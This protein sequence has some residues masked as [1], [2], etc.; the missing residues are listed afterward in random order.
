MK[1]SVPLSI[2]E[3]NDIVRKYG[4]IAV[5][6]R[7]GKYYLRKINGKCI[8]LKGNICIIQKDKPIA[9]RLWPFYIFRK[10]I[11]NDEARE[12]TFSYHGGV[13]YVYVD[14]YCPGLN[15]GEKPIRY[16]I[17]EAL[18]IYLGEKHKQKYTTSPLLSVINFNKYNKLQIIKPYSMRFNINSYSVSPDV[19]SIVRKISNWNRY[20]RN[21]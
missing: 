11:N 1:Y 2:K 12:A 3:A 21:F 14:D 5:E 7:G 20:W 4:R 10:P 19:N 9:C 16:A 13:Y 8:F 15:K 17:M 18:Q 6:K